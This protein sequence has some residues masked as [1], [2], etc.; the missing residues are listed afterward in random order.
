[1]KM[2]LTVAAIQGA[3]NSVLCIRRDAGKSGSRFRIRKG[4]I[5]SQVCP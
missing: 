2:L 1:M 4:R 3:L 5:K